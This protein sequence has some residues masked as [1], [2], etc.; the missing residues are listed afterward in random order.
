MDGMKVLIFQ[1]REFAVRRTAS[2]IAGK[3]KEAPESTLGL[4]TGGTMEPV[5]ARL[6]E[7]AAELDCSGLSTF[8]LDEY[9][10][11]ARTHPQ[12]Y[13]QYMAKHLL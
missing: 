7:F 12:S 2:L 11:L 4:A 8:N 3:I 6:S 1:R 5:Y 9:V 10:G 13:R